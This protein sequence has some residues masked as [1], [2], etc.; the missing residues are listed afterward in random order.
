MGPHRRCRRVRRLSRTRPALPGAVALAVGVLL[1]LA[2]CSDSEP[3]KPTFFGR[4]EGVR[5]PAS[6]PEGL[7]PLGAIQSCTDRPVL[8]PAEER[9]LVARP[10][11]FTREASLMISALRQAVAD[12]YRGQ[13]AVRFMTTQRFVQTEAQAVAEGR[14]CAALIVFWEVYGSRALELSVPEPTRIPL[15]AQIHPRLCEFGDYGEQLQI[16]YLT[17]TGLLAMVDNDYETATVDFD[18]ATRIDSHCL[19]L[20]K[21]ARTL[22][23][24]TPRA[25]T[26]HASPP[27]R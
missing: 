23:A 3:Y 26:G 18:Q 14:R 24:A 19:Q 2:A 16:L 22:R 12:N 17:I 9:V 8:D 27:P 11:L 20:P 25:E 4:V 15:K 10:D 7:N 6:Q 5:E 1:A 13:R 21:D